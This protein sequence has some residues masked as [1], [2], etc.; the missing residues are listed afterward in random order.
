[1]KAA[2]L[3]GKKLINNDSCVSRHANKA[4]EDPEALPHLPPVPRSAIDAA[5]EKKEHRDQFAIDQ[6]QRE[7]EEGWRDNPSV[8]PETQMAIV[9]EY[10]ALHEKFKAEGLYN[11]RYD[12]YAWE[13]LRYSIL[14][15]AFGYFLYV[16]WYMTSAVFLGLF[17]VC[18]FLPTPAHKPHPRM[19]CT[20]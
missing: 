16:K 12:A 20:P 10:R 13:F 7:R 15:A 4:V 11:P 5:R 2:V 9:K 8:D 18:S 17:W 1:V 6:E 3:V 19:T 14:F